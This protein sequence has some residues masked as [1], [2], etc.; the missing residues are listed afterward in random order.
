[1]TPA[2]FRALF[3]KL[4]RGGEESATLVFCHRRARRTIIHESRWFYHADP[5]YLVSLA[6]DF[7]PEFH[8]QPNY[9]L[10]FYQ[11]RE[12]RPSFRYLQQALYRPRKDRFELHDVAGG[13]FQR[14]DYLLTQGAIFTGDNDLRIASITPALREAIEAAEAVSERREFIWVRAH[15]N[16]REA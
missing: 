15:L 9:P 5:G 14:V 4:Y 12:S 8:I 10:E 1:M 6:N 2:D 3:W 7:A 13:V 16:R 11:Q